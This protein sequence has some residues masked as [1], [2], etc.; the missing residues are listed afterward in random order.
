MDCANSHLGH[1]S[2]LLVE[3]PT[4]AA[5]PSTELDYRSGRIKHTLQSYLQHSCGCNM[6]TQADAAPL[7]W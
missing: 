6:Y 1:S 4:C 5:V 7:T 2:K 3:G